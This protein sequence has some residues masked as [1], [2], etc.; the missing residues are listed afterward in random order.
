MVSDMLKGTLVRLAA[1]EPKEL[2]EGAVR[3]NQDSEYQRLSMIEPAHQISVKR[4]TE[5]AEKDQ[6]KDPPAFYYFAIRTLDDDRMVGS[7]ELGGDIFPHGEAF[8]GIGI[9]GREDWNKGYGT[10]AMRV[11]LRYAF[12]ELSLRRVALSVL[13]N[14]T[15]GI[16]SY[17]KAGFVREGTTRGMT[18]REGQRWNDVIMGILREEWL[19]KGS[20]VG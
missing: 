14:N 8:V 13:E 2:A 20:Q 4:L 17:E 9:G 19:T 15:R 16:R 11:L 6:E 18:L 1:V 7:C 12:N 10:D 5:W 3:W